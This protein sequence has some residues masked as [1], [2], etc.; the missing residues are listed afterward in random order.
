MTNI[1]IVIDPEESNYT[2][3]ERIKEIPATADVDYKVDL[4]FDAAPVTARKANSN[5]LRESIAAKQA[6]VANS[7]RLTRKWDIASPQ[8]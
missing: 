2:A 5:S 6:A 3:L 1:L 4:Y 8:A 7:L